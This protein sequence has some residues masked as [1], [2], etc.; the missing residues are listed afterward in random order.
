[1]RDEQMYK[2]E[3]AKRLDKI[4]PP[5]DIPALG[6]VYHGKVRD[7]YVQDEHIIMV[8]TDNLSTFD[9]VMETLIPYKGIVLNMFAKRAFDQVKD[10]LPSAMVDSPDPSVVV[11]KKLTNVWIEWVV[12]GYM[13]WRIAVAYET[14]ER[15]FCGIELWDGLWSY[16]KLP[17]P[18]FTPTTKYEASDRNLTPED[19]EALVGKEMADLVQQKAIALYARGAAVAKEKWFILIDTKYEFW[20]DEKGELYLIDEMH[21]PDSSRYCT[22][23]EWEAKFPCIQQEMNTGKRENVSQLLSAKPE[24]K[25]KEY[26]KQYIRDVVA[27]WWVTYKDGKIVADKFP[28]LTDEQIIE[29]VYRYV[30]T[31]EDLTWEVF[32]FSVLDEDP[33]E[34][35]MRNLKEWGYIT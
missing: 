18:L 22:V 26:S 1:M 13:W 11:Q 25:L 6:E 29:M 9:H 23:Q 33:K 34:R 12:R 3:I 19:V 30:S 27:Q 17:T 24:L 7:V 28:K 16:E 10:I 35:L 5:S 4:L 21:T 20:T 2:Q 32:D 15:N 14:W 31:Y 8:A